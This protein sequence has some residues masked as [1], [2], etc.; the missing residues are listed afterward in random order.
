MNGRLPSIT[1]EDVRELREEIDM[2][3][4]AVKQTQSAVVMLARSI[5]QLRGCDEDTRHLVQDLNEALRPPTRVP[6]VRTSCA[7]CGSHIVHHA[8]EAGEFLICPTCGWSDFVAAD[9]ER[10]QIAPPAGEHAAVS[11]PAGG[12]V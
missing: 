6:A 11:S 3:F 5:E 8:A 9:G 4:A 10:E 1:S 2:I 7:N 12:W